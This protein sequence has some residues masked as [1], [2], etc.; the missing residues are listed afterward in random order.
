MTAM[1][2]MLVLLAALF[3][4]ALGGLYV[5]SEIRYAMLRPGWR[6]LPS[7]PGLPPDIEYQLWSHEITGFEPRDLSDAVAEAVRVLTPLFGRGIIYSA[8]R[9][10]RVLVYQEGTYPGDQCSPVVLAVS[11][12]ASSRTAAVEQGLGG[13]AHAIAHLVERVNGRA[14]TS[15]HPQW[16][17]R[18]LEVV[19]EA[20]EKRQARATLRAVT[21]SP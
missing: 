10:S 17:E 3:G 9:G 8:L 19:L 20:Y 21:P 5:Y 13:V 15:L 4:V 2:L 6:R 12:G 16:R 7:R 11:A 18:G 1:T 14:D